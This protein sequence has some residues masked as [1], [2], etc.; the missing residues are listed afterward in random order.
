MK[1]LPFVSGI[2]TAPILAIFLRS[3]APVLALDS[4]PISKD[5]S[6]FLPQP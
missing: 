1:G 3:R 2:G 5:R 4:F 6:L